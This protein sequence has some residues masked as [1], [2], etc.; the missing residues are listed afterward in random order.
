MADTPPLADY[1]CPHFDGMDEIERGFI[2]Q[3]D[4]ALRAVKDGRLG[5]YGALEQIASALHNYAELRD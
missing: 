3:I 5:P 2:A 4:F 1:E